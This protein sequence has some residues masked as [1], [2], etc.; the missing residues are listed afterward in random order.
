L[1]VTYTPNRVRQ[2]VAQIHAETMALKLLMSSAKIKGENLTTGRVPDSNVREFYDFI[3]F[4][5]GRYKE[6]KIYLP[7]LGIKS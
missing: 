2:G 3:H 6:Q 4:L 5:Y 7:L 1:E